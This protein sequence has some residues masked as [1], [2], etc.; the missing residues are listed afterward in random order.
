MT[1]ARVAST[2]LMGRL[3]RHRSAKVLAQTLHCCAW[4]PANATWWGL[5]NSRVGHAAQCTAVSL[6]ALSMAAPISPAAHR[7]YYARCCVQALGHK[8]QWLQVLK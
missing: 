4:V 8:V 3:Q 6:S 2:S 1:A 5:S 7:W